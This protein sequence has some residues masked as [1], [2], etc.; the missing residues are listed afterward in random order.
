M[1]FVGSID[2]APAVFEGGS[3]S[4]A[5][6]PVD[7]LDNFNRG[8]FQFEEICTGFQFEEICINFLTPHRNGSHPHHTIGATCGTTS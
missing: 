1:D 6:F 7:A 4:F 5:V 3:V 2:W 8:T